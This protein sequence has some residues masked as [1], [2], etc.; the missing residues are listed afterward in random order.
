M[1]EKYLLVVLVIAGIIIGYIGSTLYAPSEPVP[2]PTTPT[3]I[4]PT[5]TPTTPMPTAP[6][7]RVTA[8][9]WENGESE[10][11]GRANSDLCNYLEQ[12][13]RRV[14][15]QAKCVFFAKD[16]QEIKEN[17]KV[18]ELRFRFYENITIS[19]WIEPKDRDHIKT[20][21]NGYRILENVNYV[22]FIL[23]DNLDEGLEAHILVHSLKYE[24]GWS[25]WAIQQDGELDKTWI[26][27]IN[28]LLSEALT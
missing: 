14:N 5:T 27:E 21:E 7:D 17:D 3:P 26:D 11:V 8:E 16:I 22:L 10:L 28:K 4:T 12:T 25:C 23:E 6:L 20:D 2:T 19:Q 1:K 24:K 13:V 18:M 9:I 15:L